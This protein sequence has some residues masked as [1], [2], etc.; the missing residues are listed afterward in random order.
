MDLSHT[1]HLTTRYVEVHTPT[2]ALFLLTKFGEFAVRSA[3]IP[4]PG[5]GEL[6]IKN[7]AVALNPIDWKMQTWGL[8]IQHY[9]AIIGL[10]TAGT[11]EAVGEGVTEFQKGDRVMG[12]GA[13]NAR[14]STFQQYSITSV[15]SSAKV[16]QSV[17]LEQAASLPVGICTATVGLYQTNE[18]GAG[19]MAPWEQGGQGKY[20]GKPFIVLGGASCNG[21]YVIQLAKLS[22]FSPIITTASPHNT[23]YL[24]SLGATHVLDRHLDTAALKSEVARIT[25]LPVKVI[26]D[27]VS[28]QDTQKLGYELL[29]ENG[30]LVLVLPSTLED[31][32]VKSAEENAL[33]H[34]EIYLSQGPGITHASGKTVKTTSSSPFV[35]GNENILSGLYANLPNYL[36]TG[37]IQA[38]R[39]E[40]L[41]G[42][43]EGNAGGL[44]RMRNGRVSGTKLV[45][46]PQDTA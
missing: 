28:E 38:V 23:T 39:V 26:Y 14:Q 31:D 27:T 22:G 5:R 32:R 37:A 6:L 30:T 42:G 12:F 40:I 41:P 4:K 15:Q 1:F 34:N 46:R 29:A 3:G 25:Q 33:R 36:D 21:A 17:S 16:P 45:V 19:L 43:L 20:S 11:V 18:Y 44:D 10:D 7:E 24:E 13:L 35:P 9:P 2:K 8:V